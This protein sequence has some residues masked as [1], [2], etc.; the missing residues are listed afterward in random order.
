MLTIIEKLDCKYLDLILIHW[1]GVSKLKPED[2]K[3][4]DIRL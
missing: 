1:P 4:A 2:K 3:N